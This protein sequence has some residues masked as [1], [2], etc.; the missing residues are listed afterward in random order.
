MPELL[1]PRL[2][3]VAD[4]LATTRWG[5]EIWDAEWR[6]AWG[7][8]ETKRFLD[9]DDPDVLGYGRHLIDVRWSEPWFSS[10]DELS[11]TELVAG[12]LPY[13]AADTPGG[14]ER[15]RDMVQHAT[16]RPMDTIQA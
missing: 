7:S 12:E 1:D 10:V 15:V 8:E 6:L 14:A 4:S 11:R 2:A 3:D 16:G 13:I 5:A 9:E